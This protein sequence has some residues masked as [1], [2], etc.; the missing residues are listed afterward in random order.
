MHARTLSH[1]VQV[2]E[3]FIG[4][5]SDKAFMQGVGQKTGVRVVVLRWWWG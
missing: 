5:Q 2:T 4:S 3:M 1:R